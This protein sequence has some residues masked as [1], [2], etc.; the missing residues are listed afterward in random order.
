[1]LKTKPGN[2]GSPDTVC[3]LS[4]SSAG[5]LGRYKCTCFD[6]ESINIPNCAPLAMYSCILS[7][8]NDRLSVGERNSTTKSGQRGTKLSLSLSLSAF[9]LSKLI[10][11]ASG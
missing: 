8:R 7:W 2:T 10:Q 11:A 4:K 1:M 9:H 3:G 5:W 6:F